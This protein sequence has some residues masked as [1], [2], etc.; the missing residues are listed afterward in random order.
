MERLGLPPGV[1]TLRHADGA[2]LTLRADG[3]HTELRLDPPDGERLVAL[4][5]ALELDRRDAL[6]LAPYAAACGWPSWGLWR[7]DDN[8]NEFCISRH[9]SRR[10][11]ERL[12][13]ELEARGHKQSYWVQ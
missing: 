9:T 11:A 10:K 13:A 3:A 1:T 7:L 4:F 6:E 5:D 2:V 12:A 8:A